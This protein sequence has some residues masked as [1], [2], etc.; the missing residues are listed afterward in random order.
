MK[1]ITSIFVLMCS[2]F[3]ISFAQ[4]TKFQW[5]KSL[6]GGPFG[7][8]YGKAIAVDSLGNIYTAGTFSGTIDFD[9]GADSVKLVSADNALPKNWGLDVFISKSD[10]QGNLLWVKQIAGTAN[11]DVSSIKLDAYNNIYLTGSFC[12]TTDFNP[13]IESFNLPSGGPTSDY[14]SAFILKLDSGGNFIWAKSIIGY[15]SKV[16]L[17]SITFDNAGNIYTIGGIYNYE[18]STILLYPEKNVLVSN[19]STNNTAFM[20]KL[21][22]FGELV[23]SRQLQ[24][25]TFGAIAIDNLNHI[26]ITGSFSGTVNFGS[27]VAPY[28]LSTPGYGTNMFVLKTDSSGVCIWAKQMEGY[29]SSWGQSIS[30]DN[31]GNVYSTGTFSGKIDADP[32]AAVYML[33]AKYSQDY[34]VFILKLDSIGQFIWV[35]QFGGRERDIGKLLFT[36][37][38]GNIYCAGMFKDTASFDN[39]GGYLIS[40]KTDNSSDDIFLCKIDNQGNII[41]LKKIG[42]MYND[43]IS[44]LYVD[45]RGSIF[46]TGNYSGN[47]DFDFDESAYILNA[48]TD[49]SRWNAMF[50]LKYDQPS[51][52]FNNDSDV[53]IYPNPATNKI[54]VLFNTKIT[55]GKIRL[56]NLLGQVL[57]ENNDLNDE[58]IDIDISGFAKAVYFIDVN[59]NGVFSTGKLI[60]E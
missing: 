42:G 15:F 40:E 28:N 3:T 33:D 52:G 39:N 44:S 48:G 8:V 34:D 1:S 46:S 55:N 13:G 30:I 54:K 11:S 26:Y 38:I 58:Y 56:S 36:D 49:P 31:L 47:V 51:P 22:P 27:I 57:F 21:T 45:S 12:D 4:N 7:T 6:P 25:S 2:L 37:K 20:V 53:Y 35:R 59:N 17:A 10:N 23:W 9:P 18:G 60:K 14:P 24:S 32:G 5:A 43:N 50:I 19:I 16:T 41:W 29:S